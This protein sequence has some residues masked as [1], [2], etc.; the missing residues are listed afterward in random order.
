VQR[1]FLDAWEGLPEK[2][3]HAARHGDYCFHNYFFDTGDRLHVF[4][5]E[6]V[7]EE[8]CVGC[9][10]FCNLVVYAD[11]FRVFSSGPRSYA[12]LFE[13]AARR[14]RYTRLLQESMDAFQRT[15][16]AGAAESR[17][18]LVYAYL[19]LLTRCQVEHEIRRR[20]TAIPE[21]LQVL[22]RS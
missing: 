11:C 1:A 12:E 10:F 16:A 18:L 19:Y 9:D 4:D 5:W 13:T 2:L 21:L 8:D 14:S 15:Y 17:V 20:L 6:F 3:P 22:S 7:A